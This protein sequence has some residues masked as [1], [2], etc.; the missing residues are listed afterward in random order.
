MGS[1]VS[2]IL[3]E[4]KKYTPANAAIR[5]AIEELET[6]IKATEDVVSDVL[7]HFARGDPNSGEIVEI[8]EIFLSGKHGGCNHDTLPDA[9]HDRIKRALKML[10]TLLY[11]EQ[12]ENASPYLLQ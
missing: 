10:C 12:E 5:N 4:Q 3:F 2:C 1:S 6:S 9:E 7:C 11:S 8:S